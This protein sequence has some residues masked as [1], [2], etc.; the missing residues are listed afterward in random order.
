MVAASV[1]ALIAQFYPL[2]FP[3][4]RWLLGACAAT[5]FLLSGVLQFMVTFLDKDFIYK[6]LPRTAGGPFAVLRSSLPKASSVYKCSVELP[7][8]TV[9]ARLEHSVGRYF[10][11]TGF[12][13]P[14]TIERDVKAILKGQE[15]LW[16]AAAAPVQ[17]EASKKGKKNS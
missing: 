7:A 6:S 2:P 10:A 1:A 8:G 9:I 4:N 17:Q 14:E 12:L 3:A 13:V 16:D 11:S 15:K 5:Y